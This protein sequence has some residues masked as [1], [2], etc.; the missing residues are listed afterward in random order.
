MLTFA[1]IA[2][3]F[4][5]FW[6]LFILKEDGSVNVSGLWAR[7][8]CL[9]FHLPRR[10]YFR[11]ICEC[12]F[13]LQ[14]IFLISPLCFFAPPRHYLSIV[15]F[16]QFTFKNGAKT[17]TRVFP[18]C[19]FFLEK[20]NFSHLCVDVHGFASARAIFVTYVFCVLNGC[21]VLRLLNYNNPHS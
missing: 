7:C 19:V 1:A 3:F 6:A 2:A 14:L 17:S 9:L 4:G 8:K 10:R 16:S 15:N 5:N 18:H 13:Q 12:S 20:S 21:P 11:N